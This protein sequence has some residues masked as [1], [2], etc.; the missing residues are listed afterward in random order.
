MSEFRTYWGSCWLHRNTTGCTSKGKMAQVGSKPAL[1]PS[2]VELNGPH[3][4][5]MVTGVGR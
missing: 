5:L 3:K 2:Q 4:V 1:G